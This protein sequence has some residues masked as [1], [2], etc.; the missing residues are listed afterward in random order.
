M[1]IIQQKTKDSMTINSAP[2]KISAR[3]VKANE[4]FEPLREDNGGRCI[5]RPFKEYEQKVLRNLSNGFLA[6]GLSYF[7]FFLCGLQMFNCL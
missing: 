1:T 3:T 2:V 6:T 5:A 7:S 4:E